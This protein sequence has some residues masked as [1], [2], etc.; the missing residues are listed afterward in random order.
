M[1]VYTSKY[2]IE[3]RK[4]KLDE[5]CIYVK[6]LEWCVVCNTFCTYELTWNR[7][8]MITFAQCKNDIQIVLE[9]NWKENNRTWKDNSKVFC[10]LSV[11]YIFKV[12][13][14][15]ICNFSVSISDQ[16]SYL[17]I[18]SSF[19]LKSVLYPIIIISSSP[20]YL[21]NHILRVEAVIYTIL[22]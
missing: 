9:N 21:P 15:L 11:T 20:D 3:N 13:S 14:F 12:F 18:D 19:L 1:Y 7:V 6:L 2:R 22:C 8:V 16:W 10:V 17:T 5:K 4:C